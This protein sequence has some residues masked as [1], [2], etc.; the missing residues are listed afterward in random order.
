MLVLTSTPQKLLGPLVLSILMVCA[1][2]VGGQQRHPTPNKPAKPSVPAAAPT[3]ET[4]LADNRYTVYGEVRGVGQLIRSNAVTELLEPVMKIAGPP[5]E[6]RTLVKWLNTNADAVMTS[7]MLVAAW[8]IAKNNLPD[9][10]VAIEFASPEEAAK[11]EAQLNSVLPKILPTPAPGGSP[12]S[13]EKKPATPQTANTNTASEP[14]YYL[15]QTGS[16]LFITSTPLNLRNLRPPGSR[17]LSENS[18]FRMAHDRFTGEQV[19]VFVDLKAIEKAETAARKQLDDESKKREAGQANQ[20][21][22]NP[23]S[24][25][26][27]AVPVPSI[28]ADPEPPPKPVDESAAVLGTV[29]NSNP[30]NQTTPPDQIGAALSTV[31]NAFF[32]APQKWPDAFAIAMSIDN[33]SLD[34]HAL[35]VDSLGE[36][37]VPIPFATMLIPGPAISPE[38]PSILPADTELFVTMSVDLPQLYGAM[39]KKM[40]PPAEAI[41]QLVKET[42]LNSPF[43]ELEKKTGI[44]IKDE[45]LPLL[46]SEIVF[47]MPEIQPS[48]VSAQATEP[49]KENLA[50]K[51]PSG[52]TPIIALSLRDKEGMRAL[53]PRLVDS[54]GF[55]GAAA[56]SQV[57][58][59]ED[60]ELVS[61]A[62][63]FAYAFVGNFLVL[64]GDAAAVRHVVD[65]YLK[66]QT[67]GSDITFRNYTRWQPRQLQGQV[68]VS[69]ALMESYKTWA[70]EPSSMISDQ[71]REFL[72]RLTVLSQPVTYALSNDG[73]GELHELHIPKNL[74]LMAVAGISGDS[75]PSPTLANE[76]NALGAI[77][78]IASAEKEY[79]ST[80]GTGSYG[81]LEQLITEKP[82]LRGLVENHG[83]KIDVVV[84]GDRFEVTATPMEYGKTGRMS[85]FVDDTNV[86]RGGDHGGGAATIS[87]KPINQ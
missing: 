15:K 59:R 3:F 80:R 22:R 49:G 55:K 73:F 72:T 64:S 11:F 84:I 77:Y 10:L 18:N 38:S 85:Y 46:G 33:E 12:F 75:N 76:R 58:K 48:P 67:L 82:Y 50:P 87:D 36:R 79:K 1:F 13:K 30:G 60:T 26:V 71:T 54:L 19:F 24:E 61:Y 57:E 20:N 31:S 27:T 69:P 28:A 66:R 52:P 53:L 29:E 65:A 86:V 16:L 45:L 70:N 8:P 78:S 14:N 32:S 17:L 41:G 51:P 2:D 7:R 83:Y 4:L 39:T 37:S 62:N 35:M 81:T 6:F 23:P 74:L 68:Y 34:V 21:D 40:R 42:E 44:R 25:T 43:A 9:F 63:A 47:S 56:F 5:K